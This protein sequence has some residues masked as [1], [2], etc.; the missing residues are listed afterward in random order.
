MGIR[1][2]VIQLFSIRTFKIQFL[3]GAFWIDVLRPLMN[4]MFLNKYSNEV[5]Q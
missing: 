4:Y 5:L 3:A 2:Y 1:G